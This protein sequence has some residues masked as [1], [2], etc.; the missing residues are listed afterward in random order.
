MVKSLLEC[1]YTKYKYITILEEDLFF[2]KK[3]I[4][5]VNKILKY[6]D[7]NCNWDMLRVINT[8]KIKDIDS[9]FKVDLN[10][11]KLY[12]FTSVSSEYLY[13]NSKNTIK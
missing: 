10:C 4:K 2:N 11:V 7:S 13:N 8:Y 3:S 1:E 6:L 12:K 5:K 9:Q